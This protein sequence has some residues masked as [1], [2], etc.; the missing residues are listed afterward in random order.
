MELINFTSGYISQMSVQS[1]PQKLSSPTKRMVEISLEDLENATPS[2]EIMVGMLYKKN[3]SDFIESD[4]EEDFAEAP[5]VVSTPSQ[6]EL[7]MSEIPTIPREIKATLSSF[8]L[9][10][11]IGDA[12]QFIEELAQVLHMRKYSVGDV[13]IRQGSYARAMFFI[14]KGTLK[15]ISEDGEVE[16]GELASGTY[17]IINSCSR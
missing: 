1:R 13:I 8:P 17:C 7:N 16:I 15:V 6:M 2:I 11:E 3:R 14:V 5:T 9:F 4:E 12:T 10:S